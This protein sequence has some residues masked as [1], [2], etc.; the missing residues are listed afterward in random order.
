[1]EDK[2]AHERINNLESTV[3][4]HLIEHSKFEKALLEN[5]RMTAQIAENTTELVTLV[6]GAKGLRTFMVWVTPLVIACAAI[7]A[8]IRSE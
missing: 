8:W 2:R 4:K 5:T 6:R 1:M 7:V 3:E